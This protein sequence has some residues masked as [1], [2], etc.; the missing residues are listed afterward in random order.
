MHAH[1]LWAKPKALGWGFAPTIGLKG[2]NEY[3]FETF[4]LS[5]Q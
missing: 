5:D 1:T 2:S 3:A 4:T